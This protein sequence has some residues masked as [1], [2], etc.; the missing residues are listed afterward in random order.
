MD[1]ATLTADPTGFL[2]IANVL[3][4]AGPWGIVII[5]GFWVWR[6]DGILRQGEE[7]KDIALAEQND[8]MRELVVSVT[9][10]QVEVT[11]ALQSVQR[12]LEKMA[13][14]SRPQ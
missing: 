5:L 12:S 14:D 7:K 10:T 11:Q 2:A 1:P 3:Q 13:P 6:Q 8:R 9:K 4:T